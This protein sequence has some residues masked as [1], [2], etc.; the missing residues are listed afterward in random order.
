MKKLGKSMTEIISENKSKLPAGYSHIKKLMSPA[1]D[2]EKFKEFFKKSG[3][4]F[5]IKPY[6]DTGKPLR[7]KIMISHSNAYAFCFYFD[8]EGN[9]LKK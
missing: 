5:G 1:N 8:S 2:L 7:N 6:N 4:E 3:I 9:L